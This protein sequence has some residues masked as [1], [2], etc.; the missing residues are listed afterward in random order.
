MRIGFG[1]VIDTAD[2][3][4]EEELAFRHALNNV[5]SRA[6]RLLWIDVDAIAEKVIGQNLAHS[7]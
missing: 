7:S 1:A 5:E 6:H 4:N 2:F 3:L